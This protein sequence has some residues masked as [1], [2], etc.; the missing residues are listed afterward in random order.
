MFGAFLAAIAGPIAKRVLTALGVG[1]VSYAAVSLAL[2]AALAA[3][4][5]S[6]AGLGGVGFGEA[7]ALAQMAGVPTAA[8]IFAGALI[9]SVALEFTK[10]IGKLN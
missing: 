4:K 2:N 3:A 9:A 5:Q 10:K 8:S 1:V 7:L 6:W